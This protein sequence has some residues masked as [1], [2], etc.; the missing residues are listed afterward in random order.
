MPPEHLADDA[1]FGAGNGSGSAMLK[2]LVIDD[3]PLVRR[4]IEIVLK[5]GGH[6]VTTASNGLLGLALFRDMLPDL[7]VTDIIMPEQEGLGT[8]MAIRREFPAAKII[9]I[10]GGG[11]MGN[12]DLLAAARLLGADDA[13]AKPFESEVLLQRVACLASGAAAPS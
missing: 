3:D 2:I 7:V 4:S 10:S 1:C 12:L 6:R 13:I 9:A 11:R 5:L 8:I